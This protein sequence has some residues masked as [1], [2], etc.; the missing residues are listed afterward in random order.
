MK[1]Q[2]DI[3]TLTLTTGLNDNGTVKR[4][5]LPREVLTSN[6]L[7]VATVHHCIP[8]DA[9]EIARLFAA[10]PVMLRALEQCLDVLQQALKLGSKND[11]QAFL[12]VKSAIELATK[13]IPN[14]PSPVGQLAYTYEVLEE[15][16]A[17]MAKAFYKASKH[18]RNK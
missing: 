7:L 15:S 16:E 13:K 11:T 14:P 1:P 8:N 3:K 17:E 18:L 5:F 12:A 4:G 9:N 6:G 10:S 2:T